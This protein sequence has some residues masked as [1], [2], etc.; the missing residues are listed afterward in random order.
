MRYIIT[1]LFLVLAL[2]FNG[3]DLIDQMPSTQ[4]PSAFCKNQ[5]CVDMGNWVLIQPSSTVLVYLLAALTLWVAYHFYQTNNGER[6]RYWWGVSL[7]LGGIGAFLAGTSY[8]AFGYEIKCADRAICNWTSAWEIAYNVATVWGA[9][10]LLMAVTYALLGDKWRKPAAI[11]AIVNS[12][13][14]MMATILG[15][16]CLDKNWLCFETMILFTTPAY[17][18]ILGINIGQYLKRPST[19]LKAYLGAWGILLFC[20]LSYGFYQAKGYTAILW[21]QGW[22]FS[23]NDVLHLIMLFWMIYVWQVLSKYIFD[24]KPDS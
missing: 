15:L 22:W 16:L 13:T 19:L 17:L 23:E 14:Y 24:F 21:K 3:C 4:T 20:M 6:S 7:F 18:L 5:P 1:T 2:M 11:Y 9:N 10:A 8:Q 12:L